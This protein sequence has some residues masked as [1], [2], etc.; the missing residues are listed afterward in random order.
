LLC[1]TLHDRAK[2][3]QLAIASHD[4]PTVVA[5]TIEKKLYFAK[6]TIA[7]PGNAPSHNGKSRRPVFFRG[8]PG[9]S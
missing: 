1:V 9:V 7:D 3:F 2:R 6:L 8:I 5:E 4:T